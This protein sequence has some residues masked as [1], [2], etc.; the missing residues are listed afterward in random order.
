M[1]DRRLI[2]NFDWGLLGL[3]LVLSLM[4]IMT[5]YS[6]VT[7]GKANVQDALYLKQIV[8]YCAGFGVMI[9]SFLFN[10][11]TLD[12]WALVIYGLC[13]LLLVL[14]LFFGKYVGGSR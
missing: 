12:R 2:Q 13:I 5:L 9:I 4:G 8:W 7:A 10:Y 1:I 14:V 6:A 3:T 11:K